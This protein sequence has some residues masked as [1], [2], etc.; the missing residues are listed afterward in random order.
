MEFEKV[1]EGTFNN[2]YKWISGDYMIHRQTWFYGPDGGANQEVNYVLTYQCT[3]LHN[4]K[5]KIDTL[6]E[7]IDMANQH[8]VTKNASNSE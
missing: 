7:A 4:L 2:Q 1:K 5:Y 6:Q 3:R 8:E